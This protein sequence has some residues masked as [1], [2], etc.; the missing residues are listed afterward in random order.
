MGGTLQ[1]KPKCLSLMPFNS[2]EKDYL[3][4]FKSHFI[5]DVSPH[6]HGA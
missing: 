4:D 5:L 6:A 2:V 1:E 3:D